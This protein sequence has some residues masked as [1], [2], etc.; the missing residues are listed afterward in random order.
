MDIAQL[1]ITNR[2][3]LKMIYAGIIVLI[4]FFIVLRTDRLF[5]LS[6]HQGI[7]YFRNAFFFFGIAFLIRYSVGNGYLL[8]INGVYNEIVRGLFEFFLISAG[9][10]LLYSLIWKKIETEK[11]S[12]SSLFNP[13]FMIFYFMAFIISF[14]DIIWKGYYFMFAS[15]II[16]FITASVIS[17]VNYKKSGNKHG[18]LGFYFIAMML[19]LFAWIINAVIPIYFNWHAA[20]LIDVYLLNAAVFVLFLYGVFRVTKN[21][22]K[23]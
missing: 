15:Q 17:L 2:E 23:P 1:I 14:L 8:E 3:I 10:A 21:R 16:I 20:G 9:F 5:K 18:F 4:C 13:R 19:S 7:R 22:K 12:V 11:M 6:L